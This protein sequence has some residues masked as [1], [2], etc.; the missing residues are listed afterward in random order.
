MRPKH[1]NKMLARAATALSAVGLTS[2]TL[3][4]SVDALL[5]KL[6]EKGVL[7]VKEANELRE[8]ADKGFTQA[9]QIKTGLPD[10]VTSLKFAGDLRGR[11]EGFYSENEAFNTRQRLRYR[12]RAG[13]TA[14]MKDNF[15]VGF[16]LTASESAGGFTEGD[17]ISGNQT[18]GNNASRKLVFMDLAYA[19]WAAVNRPG[20]NAALTVGKM[21]NPF[22]FPSTLLFD[23]DYTP[24]GLAATLDFALGGDQTLKL[25]GAGFALDE[26]AAS[27]KDPYLLGGQTRLDSKWNTKLSSSLGLG[28]LVILNEKALTSA[29]VP[30]IGRGNTRTAAGTLVEEFALVYADAGLT[31]QVEKFPGYTGAFPIALS[32]DYL[33]NTR[34]SQANQGYSIGVTFGRAGRRG[35]WEL[36]YRWA[37]LQADAWYEEFTESDF[38]AFYQAAPVGGGAGYASGTNLR[39]H[40]VRGSFSPFDSLTLSVSYFLTEVITEHPA[41]SESGMGRLQVDAVWKF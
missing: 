20:W 5:D 23:R 28:Y 34:V 2:L 15:E 13:F 25:A 12:L 3:A 35:L 27:G 9:H 36:T 26:L 37:E 7:T 38:G 19:K 32:G 18:F 29:N 24:E 4:Q 8:E 40:T 1:L 14:V 17:P 6:V 22:V 31:Y 11:F 33:H 39:G 10:W 41:G 16:R 21:E 30:N